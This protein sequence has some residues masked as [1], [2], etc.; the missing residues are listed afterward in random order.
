MNPAI[1][2][3][4]LS[5]R[6]FKYFRDVVYKES[7][8]KLTE[9][10]KA[11]VQSRIL[12]RMRSLHLQTFEEYADYLKQHYSYEL[13]NFIN[14]VTTNKTNFFREHLH[15]DFLRNTA[16]PEI[17]KQ[18]IKE[19]RLWSAGCSTGEEAYTLAITAKEYFKYK[20]DFKIKILA[21]DI[22][23]QVLAKAYKGIYKLEEL[24][25]IDEN[26]KKKYFIKGTTNENQGL[27]KISKE[28]RDLI[29]F[30]R[31]NLLDAS[32]PMKKKFH[33]IFCRNVII[34]FDKETQ[35]ILFNKIYK[36]LDDNG[37]LFIGHSENL[38]TVSDSFK[39][40]GKTIYTKHFS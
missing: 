35:K 19:L 7:G 11:L 26:L 16:F 3:K 40:I 5:D 9:L 20:K 24:E 30:K 36:Y 10:K 22:D 37:Y 1:I 4:D 29:I 6:D 17:E 12:K 31:L 34:Y 2:I 27:Y 23:T 33:Y 8:I 38:T 18:G 14:S 21:T 13:I 28:I 15:F 25:G 32:Y 39:L